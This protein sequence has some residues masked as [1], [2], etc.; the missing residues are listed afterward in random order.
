MIIISLNHK[1]NYLL[2]LIFCFFIASNC[3]ATRLSK[4]DALIGNRLLSF[5]KSKPVSKNFVFCQLALKSKTELIRGIA[6]LVLFKHYG[7]SYNSFIDEHFTLNKKKIKF[8]RAKRHLIKMNHLDE[9]LNSETKSFNNFYDYRLK[10]FALFFYFRQKNT[11]VVGAHGEKLSL[12]KFYRTSIFRRV[13]GKELC[14]S[15][16]IKSIDIYSKPISNNTDT[17]PIKPINTN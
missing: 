10:P 11:W 7:K 16:F 5:V 3:M 2:S 9:I 15:D 12:A 17:K 13:L 1:R 4:K 8:D 14:N 6:A